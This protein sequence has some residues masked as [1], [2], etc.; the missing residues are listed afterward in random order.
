ME[1]LYNKIQEAQ[2]K[3]N[4]NIKFCFN[5]YGFQIIYE[6]YNENIIQYLDKRNFNIDY[7][8]TNIEDIYINNLIENNRLTG[9]K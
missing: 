8:I 2:Q 9:D 4:V 3:F 6:G 7:L 1:I 5:E